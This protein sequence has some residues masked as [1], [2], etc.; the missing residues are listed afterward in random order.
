MRW[1]KRLRHNPSSCNLGAM[2]SQSPEWSS[3]ST[4]AARGPRYPSWCAILKPATTRCG[5]APL[6]LFF[7]LCCRDN[8]LQ[9][10]GSSFEHWQCT[11]VTARSLGTTRGPRILQTFGG[12]FVPAAAASDESARVCGAIWLAGCDVSRLERGESRERNQTSR[13]AK[14]PVVSMQRNART[15]TLWT[16]GGWALWSLSVHVHYLPV[17]S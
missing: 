8:P 5:S 1:G 2:A 7:V 10:A 13:Q 9:N 12:A 16:A 6:L 15:H 11:F 14:K 3:K 4:P 17:L